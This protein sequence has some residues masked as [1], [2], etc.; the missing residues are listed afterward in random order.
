MGFDYNKTTQQP[1]DLK[2]LPEDAQPV[3]GKD[4][5]S[6]RSVQKKNIS[7]SLNEILRSQFKDLQNQNFKTRSYTYNQTQGTGIGPTLERKARAFTYLS[8]SNNPSIPT[9]K[10]RRLPPPPRPATRPAPEALRA[11]TAETEAPTITHATKDPKSTEFYTKQEVQGYLEIIK[12]TFGK[13]NLSQK[14]MD[15]YKTE[16][17]AS[18]KQ[19]NNDN[20]FDFDAY[21]KIVKDINKTILKPAQKNKA[22]QDEFT[23][24]INSD[25]NLWKDFSYDIEQEGSDGKATTLHVD[26]KQHKS[27]DNS[28]FT[29]E[30]Y[31]RSS[32]SKGKDHVRNL[33]MISVQNQAPDDVTENSQSMKIIAHA[34]VYDNQNALKE[35]L[36]TAVLSQYSSDYLKETQ[37]PIDFRY[38]N[39]QLTTT[40]ILGDGDMALKQI[41]AFN[42]LEKP[43]ILDF[44]G[45]KVGIN[46]Q[47]PLLFNFGCNLQHFKISRNTE[48][49]DKQNAQ[50][51]TILGKLVDNVPSKDISKK[52][53]IQTLWTQIQNIW[54]LK[55]YK[56]NDSEPYAIQV[57]LAALLNLLGYTTSV[58][59]KSGK[60]RTG[61][62][63]DEFVAFS[64]EVL[65]SETIP[66]PYE[67]DSR[68]LDNLKTV[69]KAGIAQRC[70]RSC[71]GICGLKIVSKFLKFTFNSVHQ[72]LG[73][74][75][76]GAYY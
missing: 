69:A 60:D 2:F 48:K 35:L 32:L 66:A 20:K 61:V 18:E 56:T 30:I 19:L 63:G 17:D 12:N 33:R 7:D 13:L 46:F 68:I 71:L 62:F 23:K 5:L 59:C 53:K 26:V 70:A 37:N 10:Q 24:Q 57:R 28:A 25:Q 75:I 14:E 55:S 38:A 34:C 40:S 72:R 54:G 50:S 11:T 36:K 9:F 4:N 74:D 43:I 51:L 49:V 27:I 1:Q 67:N 52:T 39:I 29:D 15:H 6:G 47:A 58:N 65:N 3:E 31:G 73:K 44:D 45:K 21:K 42:K 16:I 22:F 8:P 76:N 41:E 64:S